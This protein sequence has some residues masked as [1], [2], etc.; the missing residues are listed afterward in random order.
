METGHCPE[1]YFVSKLCTKWTNEEHKQHI[2]KAI[3]PWQ[4]RPQSLL[5]TL[6][7]V[8]QCP[9]IRHDAHLQL[10]DFATV[11]IPP[12]NQQPPPLLQ[13]F[14]AFDPGSQ[15]NPMSWGAQPFNSL[16][17]GPLGP[18][19]QTTQGRAPQDGSTTTTPKNACIVGNDHKRLIRYHPGTGG[20]SR[21]SS[22]DPLAANSHHR[23]AGASW[24]RRHTERVSA[25]DVPIVDWGR[26]A[27]T[28]GS[29]SPAVIPTVSPTVPQPSTPSATSTSTDTSWVSGENPE[30]TTSTD[31]QEDH[32]YSANR[33]WGPVFCEYCLLSLSFSFFSDFHLDK[34]SFDSG[35]KN[36]E[37][38][39]PY[40][41]Q[42]YHGLSAVM[43]LTKNTKD[44]Q[45]SGNTD[46]MVL[47]CLFPENATAD[48]WQFLNHRTSSGRR[49]YSLPIHS[50][51]QI[52]LI[53]P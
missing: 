50:L 33:Y 21:P 39:L 36:V 19:S 51:I 22:G 27:T 44:S 5:S 7:Q 47:L 28:E 16:P 13:F 12:M 10:S 45:I 17:F 41:L 25:H 26:G 35:E 43:R 1:K 8:T 20:A 42:E 48:W 2:Y 46:F 9:T 34:K 53:H 49:F 23:G 14:S 4:G 38:L 15:A 24:I 18:K 31:I 11:P 3:I 29:T 32:R 37:P 40:Y 6:T 52:Q 30:T